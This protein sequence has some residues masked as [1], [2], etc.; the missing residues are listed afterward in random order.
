MKLTRQ[1][2]KQE[3]KEVKKKGGRKDRKKVGR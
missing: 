1:T 3:K 2:G